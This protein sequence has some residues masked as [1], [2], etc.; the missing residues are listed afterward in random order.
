MWFDARNVNDKTHLLDLQEVLSGVVFDIAIVIV[1]C[2]TAQN[3]SLLVCTF[4]QVATRHS[5]N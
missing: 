3:E 1:H 4:L 2:L 5:V